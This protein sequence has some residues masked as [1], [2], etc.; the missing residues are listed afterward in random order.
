MKL[1]WQLAILD[2]NSFAVLLRLDLLDFANTIYLVIF[3]YILEERLKLFLN[4]DINN[5]I[6]VIKLKA[7]VVR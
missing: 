7:V 4:N 1:Y 2:E 5:N 6:N 3:K